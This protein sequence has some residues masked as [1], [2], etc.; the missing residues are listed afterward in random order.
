MSLRDDCGCAANLGQRL[1]WPLVEQGGALT[2]L[3][4]E[5]SVSQVW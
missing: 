1:E 5:E 4:G 3:E 2:A